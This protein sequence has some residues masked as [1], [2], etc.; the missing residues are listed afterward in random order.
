M[1][2]RGMCHVKLV[3][4]FYCLA[5]VSWFFRGLASVTDGVWEVDGQIRGCFMRTGRIIDG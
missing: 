1:G 5:G 2:S 3:S 4:L